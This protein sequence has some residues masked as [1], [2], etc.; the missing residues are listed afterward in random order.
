M[1]PKFCTRICLFTHQV[2][3]VTSTIQIM[4]LSIEEIYD[5]ASG[6]SHIKNVLF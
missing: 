6:P 5:F 1:V 3:L 4:H 2:E